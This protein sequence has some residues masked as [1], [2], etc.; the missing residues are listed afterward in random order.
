MN[1][2][3]APGSHRTGLLEYRA[4]YFRVGGYQNVTETRAASSSIAQRAAIGAGWIIAWRVATR[5]IGL[6]STLIL[7]R[8]LQ[9]SDFGLVSLATGFISSVDALSAIG[10][11]DALV[12]A[13]DLDRDMYDTGFSLGVMRGVM[14]A[15]LVA[16]IA[17]PVAAFF[18]EPRLCVVMLALS[19]GSLIGGF[20]NI[21]II[22]FRRD[23]AFRKEFSMQVWSRVLSVAA[24]IVVAAIWRT[25]WALIVGLLVYRT[26]RLLQ[27]YLMSSYRPH[28]TLR[29]WRRLIW[30]SLWTWGGTVVHQ[31]RERCDS[32]FIG[33]FLGAA[34]FGLFSVGL[35][36]ALL[37]VTELVEPLGRALFSGFASLHNGA[38]QLK[39]MFLG[40]VGL[41]FMIILPSGV[42]ISMVA[43]PMV[44]LTLGEQW[45]AAVP[46]IQIAAIAGT[47][48][49][50]SQACGEL[51]NAVGRPQVS[52]FISLGSTIIK[53][54][55]L[56]ALI[57]P[58][59]LRG[60]AAA[61]VIASSC[62]LLQLLRVALRRIRVSFP[63]ML[64]F[65][66]RPM[67]ATAAM[68]I[69]LWQSGM[70]WT[71]GAG[72]S[73]LDLLSDAGIRCATG[74]ATYAI[75]L[76]GVWFLVG[77]PQGSERNAMTA[78]VRMWQRASR[79]MQRSPML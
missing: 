79:L 26:G 32:I 56:V 54:I 38:V 13:P 3:F 10:V 9:P 36:L 7:V 5:N 22:D 34:Q 8:L 27:S 18:N 66:A 72:G 21:G 78:A 67:L 16:A 33:R 46:V 51:L 31:L 65:V 30:F 25:Y 69:V 20:E 70:A 24:T 74:A 59:G 35:E 28:F 55:A 53:V 75:V 50:F 42:G 73:M 60:A 63:E 44:R 57:P 71:P 49:I 11:Q 15:S 29:A 6:V 48:A 58:Y 64:G 45:L 47:M 62:D 76:V 41:G 17:W 12:R 4:R 2:A 68:V 37:P 77:R 23:L 43:D 39:D 19:V 1:D 52:L 61:I 40:A 14:T